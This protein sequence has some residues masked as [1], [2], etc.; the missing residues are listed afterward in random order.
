MNVKDV[1][2]MVL[3]APDLFEA[4]NRP[5]DLSAWQCSYAPVSAARGRVMG[6]GD[7]LIERRIDHAAGRVNQRRPC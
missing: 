3:Q 2:D 6:G 1:I 5:R 7:D 4:R